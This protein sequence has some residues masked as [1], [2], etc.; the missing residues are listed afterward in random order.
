MNDTSKLFVTGATGHLGQL[1]INDL[2]DTVAADRIVAGVRGME[3]EPAAVLSSKGVELRIADYARP[4]TLVSAFAGIDRLLLISGSEIGQRKSQH[5]A[6]ITAA[7]QVG[8]Q[9][10]AYTSI[11]RAD[12]SP[13]FLADEHRD[14]EAALA[15]SGVP[16]VLLRNG[17]YTEVYTW[18]APLALEQGLL[19]GAAKS[20]RISSA[21]RADYAKAAAIILSGEGHAG[22]T[23]ELAGDTAFTLAD[24]AAVLTEA[25][26]RSISYQNMSAEEFKAAAV[27]AGIPDVVAMILS[28]TDAGVAEGALFDDG[29]SLAELIGR[30]TTPYQK[31][32]YDF[33][34]SKAFGSR[35]HQYS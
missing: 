23:Y 12:S 27:R 6:V 4:E 33:V 7:K 10:I 28:D 24:L 17:W 26:G 2:L 34:R 35:N 16:Y 1:V 11:L 32:I 9:L 31:T 29:G 18:R 15:E 14:T 19:A 13:L 3:K 25:S 20:G 8:V 21:A 5:R 22:R 30:Q